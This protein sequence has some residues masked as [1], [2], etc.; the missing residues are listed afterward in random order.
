MGAETIEIEVEIPDMLD[1]YAVYAV[2][3]CAFDISSDG[4]GEYEF[5]GQPCFDR[6]ELRIE[7]LIVAHIIDLVAVGPDGAEAPV[8]AA[9]AWQLQSLLNNT[10]YLYAQYPGDMEAAEQA[11]LELYGEA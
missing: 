7:G 5:W 4:I 6:G 2:I 10:G 1:G 9:W 3:E 8:D 11:A